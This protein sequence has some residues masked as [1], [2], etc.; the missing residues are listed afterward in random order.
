MVDLR[1]EI[2]VIVCRLNDENVQT[3]D[4][5]ENIHE[6]GILA[7]SIVPARLSADVQQQARQTAQRLADELDYV[8]VLAVEMFVVGDTH[9]LLVN[10]TAP[11]THN[12]YHHTIDACAADQF[13]QQVRIMCN[14]PPADTKLLSLAVWR[15]FW[16]TFG[17][18]MAANRIG[19]RCKAGRMHT[20][21][22]TEK[23]HRKVGKWDTLPF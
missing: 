23:P 1:G 5:A 4:P 21:T 12:S 9:E 20:C 16:A 15:I 19:C 8:G 10:E 18:K 13:Q 11:R 2:S 7:Y 17:R 3:F 6:N 22:Y 14:L